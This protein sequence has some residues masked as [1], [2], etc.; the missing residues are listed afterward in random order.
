LVERR[1]V[2]RVFGEEIPLR[3]SV[4]VITGYSAHA[5]RTE[6]REWINGVRKGQKTSPPVYLVH[7]EA[8]P[9]AA[10][11]Q[12]LTADGFRVG[13]PRQFERVQLA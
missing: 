8:G 10:L 5:D 12:A 1:S 4:E 6:L 7:G 13:V 3:A 2:I 11:S 9:Q